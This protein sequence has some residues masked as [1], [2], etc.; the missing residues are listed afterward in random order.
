MHLYFFKDL[1]LKGNTFRAYPSKS[2]EPLS[3]AKE[4]IQ[5][6]QN[7]LKSYLGVSNGPMGSYR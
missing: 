1:W 6:V 5:G 4:Y 3:R 7:C 2:L